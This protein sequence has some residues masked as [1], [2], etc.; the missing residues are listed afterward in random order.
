MPEYLANGIS[1]S[2]VSLS[3]LSFI[4]NWFTC[5]SLPEDDSSM[6]RNIAIKLVMLNTVLAFVFTIMSKVRFL[7]NKSIAEVFVN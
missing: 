7:Q 5:F 1:V 6:S 3:A 4:N 2:L